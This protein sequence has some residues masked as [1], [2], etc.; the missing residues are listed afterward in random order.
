MIQTFDE[1]IKEVLNKNIRILEQEFN[2]DVA[3]FMVK[4]TQV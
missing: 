2:A 3:F 1:T 4:Y